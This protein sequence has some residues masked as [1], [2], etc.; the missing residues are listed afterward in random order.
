V[1]QDS[2]AYQEAPNG[3]IVDGYTVVDTASDKNGFFADALQNNNQIVIA[4]RGTDPN[5]IYNLAKTLLADTSWALPNLEQQSNS[6]NAILT[7]EVADAATFLQKVRDEFQN[8][9]ITIT[10]HSLGGAIAQ[11][12]GLTSN[13]TAVGFNA[14]GAAQFESE[15]TTALAPATNSSDLILGR[16]NINIRLEGD[17]V[18]LAGTSIG[19]QWTIP[20]PYTATWQN[21]LSNHSLDTI[22]AVLGSNPSPATSISVPGAITGTPTDS[23]LP[24]SSLIQPVSSVLSG[25]TQILGIRFTVVAIA[26]IG[27]AT[28][29]IVA[30]LYSI[31]PSLT[32][33]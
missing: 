5:D 7:S 11:L 29:A 33:S 2:A 26:A 19:T 8:D 14:P 15:L 22:R 21:F 24:L 6:P 28:A 25:A 16:P 17:Q 13:Y 31:D 18:S 30:A 12:L 9:I 23:P 20:S 27:A 3:S 4:I 10:G 32:V 1:D